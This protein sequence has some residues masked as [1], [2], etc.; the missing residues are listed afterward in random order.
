M[1]DYYDILGVK[2]DATPAEIRT[3]YRAGCLKYHPDRNQDD[4]AAEQKMKDLNEAHEVLADPARREEYDNPGF[5]GMPGFQGTMSDMFSSLF[6][7]FER[8][9]S[10]I[11]NIQLAISLK[12][13]L[14][15][16]TKN[17][18]INCPNSFEEKNKSGSFSHTI[19]FKLEPFPDL[20]EVYAYQH[21]FKEDI[22][23]CRISLQL[24]CERE[25]DVFPNGNAHQI[26][27]IPF[28]ML[29]V[30]GET[31][32]TLLNDE[33][34]NLIIPP[35]TQPGDLLEIENEGFAAAKYLRQQVK[36]KRGSLFFK[37]K[38]VFP[39]R[40]SESQVSCLK[41]FQAVTSSTPKENN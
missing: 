23:N 22:L 19:P 17:I 29:V 32:V 10:A 8:A 41:Q 34:K 37:I 27:E 7:H 6:N 33:K 13:Y 1:K 40:L 30:G 2:Q 25:M 9:R 18:V 11:Y 39:T 14:T 36:T 31:E 5:Q 20:S 4:P 16:A 38:P 28:E 35:Y 21:K 26:L 12:E 3:A 24:I 15:G